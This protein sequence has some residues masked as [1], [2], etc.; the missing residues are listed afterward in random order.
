MLELT[1]L[2]NLRC[3]MCGIWSE[4]P[5]VSIP[6]GDFQRLL[7]Q[8]TIRNAPVLGLTGGEPFMLEDFEDYYGR[9]A[10]TCPRSHINISTNGWYTK[11]TL[12]LLSRGDR[13]RTSVTIS[14]DGVRSHDAVRR[15]EGSQE[16]LLDTAT[17][18]RSEFPEVRLS[19]KLT[20]TD[21]NY[22]EIED[23]A[24]QCQELEIPFRFKTLE[25]LQCHQSRS[26]ADIEGPEYDA[27]TL[28]AISKQANAVLE[29]GISTNHEYI[30]RLIR[31]NE[32]GQGACSCSARTLFVGIDGKVFLCRQKDPIGNLKAN[33]LDEIW[34]SA[35][36]KQR[37]REMGVCT[38]APLGLGFTHA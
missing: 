2:C 18:I 33:S 3:A 8:K 6:I 7:E 22:Q 31:K 5:N 14:Y 29:M 30:K 15:V 23:T 28:S 20:V 4:R 16:K 27:A 36:R 32:T 37:V 11:R 25:K 17:R 38:G 9:V 24:R 1:N 26:P 12:D 13:R 19:L 21:D 34:A 10:K 35:V